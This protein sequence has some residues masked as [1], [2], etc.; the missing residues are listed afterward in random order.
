MRVW[1]RPCTLAAAA[2]WD[3]C[4]AMHTLCMVRGVVAI[5]CTACMPLN[6]LRCKSRVA[7]LGLAHRPVLLAFS[8]A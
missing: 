7:N 6:A 1:G 5:P 4:T 2:S 8:S 3:V